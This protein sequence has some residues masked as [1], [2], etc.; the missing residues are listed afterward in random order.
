M[1]AHKSSRLD[2]NGSPR[3]AA[4]HGQSFGTERKC[5]AVQPAGPLTSGVSVAADQDQPL[6]THNQSGE[7]A[8]EQAAATAAAADCPLQP[9][10]NDRISGGRAEASL[11]ADSTPELA[12]ADAIERRTPCAPHLNS[13]SST[14]LT[15]SKGAGGSK[16]GPWQHVGVDALSAAVP[17]TFEMRSYSLCLM[18]TELQT[19]P[20]V[21]ERKCFHAQVAPDH[22]YL[23]W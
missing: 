3:I 7:N 15:P 23:C 12:A 10:N 18:P 2:S 4:H 19:M 20:R 8:A 11:S 17:Q 6:L 14:A 16:E 5:G 22:H 21:H 1:D 9:D 13:K